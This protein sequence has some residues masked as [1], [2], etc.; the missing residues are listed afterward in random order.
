[1]F[2]VS[3]TWASKSWKWLDFDRFV[4]CGHAPIKYNIILNFYTSTHVIL[5]DLKFT[6]QNSE[7][8]PNCYPLIYVYFLT[9]SIY[10]QLILWLWAQFNRFQW[11]KQRLPSMVRS[12][13][14]EF[15]KANCTFI[16][17]KYNVSKI[18]WNSEMIQN[19]H[20]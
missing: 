15:I 10:L 6:N 5:F 11:N 19:L 3:F 4:L 14:K 12:H 8:F 2:K 9:R 7:N 18:P 16:A 13:L 1:M 17:L 20:S